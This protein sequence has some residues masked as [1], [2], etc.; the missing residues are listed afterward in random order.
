MYRNSIEGGSGIFADYDQWAE[1]NPALNWSMAFMALI[2]IIILIE[3][4]RRR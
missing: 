4:W 3:K 2:V 1:T